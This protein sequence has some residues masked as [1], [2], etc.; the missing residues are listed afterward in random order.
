MSKN[1]FSDKLVKDLADWI[2]EKPDKLIVIKLKDLTD[3]LSVPSKQIKVN[4]V[5]YKVW[6]RKQAGIEYSL[7]CINPGK[8]G[9]QHFMTRGH[10]HRKPYLEILI[11]VSGKG[12]FV[13][14]E[15]GKVKVIQLKP[16]QVY[17]LP[18]GFHRTVNLSKKPLIFLTVQRAGAGHD[19]AKA[20]EL[21]RKKAKELLI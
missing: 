21:I 20:R 11:P 14:V 10:L 18:F 5:I 19:Y 4:F 1:G 15:S 16:N 17:V 12:V 13:T 7:T 2:K 8:I 6:R 9:K 3:Y